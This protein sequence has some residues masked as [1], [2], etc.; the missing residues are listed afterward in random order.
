MQGHRF[1]VP[2]AKTGEVKITG[3]F[4]DSAEASIVSG[5]SIREG[6]TVRAK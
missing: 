6:N 1:L 3:V 2:G 4:D 5:D